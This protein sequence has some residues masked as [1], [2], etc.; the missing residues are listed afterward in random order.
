MQ[1]IHEY[2]DP[3]VERCKK[4]MLSFRIEATQAWASAL[5]LLL[6]SLIYRIDD[7]DILGIFS[8]QLRSTPLSSSHKAAVENLSRF[9]ASR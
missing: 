6:D 9:I 1:S 3:V 7:L 4:T 8:S 5:G 2:A